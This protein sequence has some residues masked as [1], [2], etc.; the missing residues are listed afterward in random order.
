M[1]LDKKLQ[2]N[3]D[4]LH[5]LCFWIKEKLGEKNTAHIDT[6]SDEGK[7]ETCIE[8]IIIALASGTLNVEDIKKL[9]NS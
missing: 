9:L 3:P 6:L 5:N 7:Y 8:N 2:E 1:D 4:F